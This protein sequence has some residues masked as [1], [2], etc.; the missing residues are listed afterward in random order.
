V[1]VVAAGRRTLRGVVDDDAVGRIVGVVV[2][3]FLSDTA[4]PRTEQSE[5]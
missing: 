3:N 2:Q 4:D 5:R 1:S